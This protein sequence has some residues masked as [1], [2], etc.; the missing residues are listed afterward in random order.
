M[1]TRS[2]AESLLE[3]LLKKPLSELA[4]KKLETRLQKAH[5]LPEHLA[6]GAEKSFTLHG[7][8]R[9]CQLRKRECRL[10]VQS[11][12]CYRESISMRICSN[13]YLRTVPQRGR[14]KSITWPHNATALKS[15]ETICATG[16]KGLRH[17]SDSITSATSQS[18][19]LG[20]MPPKSDSQCSEVTTTIEKYP[21]SKYM[22]KRFRKQ[23]HV[24][25]TF[26]EI[27]QEYNEE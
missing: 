3:W 1:P 9:Y 4:R 21:Y 15:S 20:L 10:V 18:S 6:V 24:Q 23:F 2:P 16:L 17:L 14:E 11:M 19:M 13:T 7:S 26:D 25:P 8:S 5:Q 12:H 22:E 27:E